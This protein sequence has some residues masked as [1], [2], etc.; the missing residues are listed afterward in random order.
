MTEQPPEEVS[1]S[2]TDIVSK[3]ELV[4]D[5]TLNSSVAGGGGPPHDPGMEA[6]VAA[7]EDQAKKTN[8]GLH[9]MEVSICSTRVGGLPA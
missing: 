8:D 9:R 6:R 7:L 3:L 1:Q 2:R 4:V 5:N